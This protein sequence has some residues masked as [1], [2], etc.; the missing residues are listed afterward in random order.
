MRSTVD[1]LDA[2]K[3]RHSLPSDYALAPFLGI[4]KQEVS[5][6]RNGKVYLGDSTALQVAKLLEIDPAEVI[7]SAYFERAKRPEEKAVW[8]SIMK[9][10]GGAA[11]C[12]VLG[13]SLVTPPPA[14]ASES[15][16]LKIMLNLRRR[17]RKTPYCFPDRLFAR[18]LGFTPPK[19]I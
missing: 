8:Q 5:K 3:S 19:Y 9:R 1:F 18:F 13:L 4:T 2:V 14:Q 17:R 6:L 16:A 10:L 12:V 15:P 11:A 7:A